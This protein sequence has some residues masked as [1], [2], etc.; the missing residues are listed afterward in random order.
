M[1]N[2]I[3]SFASR[4]SL[5]LCSLGLAASVASAE[6]S[7]QDFANSIEKYLKTDS[8]IAVVARTVHD[9][10]LESV[11]RAAAAAV[12]V[13]FVANVQ[14]RRDAAGR[15]KLMEI[16]PRFPG[17]MPLT[18]AAG[19]EMPELALGMAL[20]EEVHITGAFSEV[21]MVRTWSETFMA[22]DALMDR[23]AAQQAA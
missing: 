23:A 16:N 10:E 7:D 14:L 3:S 8:G 1:K 19:V 21:A 2:K 18:V 20:G 4:A 11:A 6:I 15:P 9:P 17:T 22:P 12:G 13:R 5:A